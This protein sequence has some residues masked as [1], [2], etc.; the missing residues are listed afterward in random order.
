MDKYEAEVLR[1]ID[2]DTFEV[3]I[4]LGFGIV[5][6]HH[7]RLLGID[8]PEMREEQGPI[9]KKFV[10]DHLLNKRIYLTDV[11]PKTDKYGRTLAKVWLDEEHID[12]TELLL[13][14]GL[15]VPYKS[16]DWTWGGG[17]FDFAFLDF[18]RKP[19]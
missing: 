17:V 10:E 4:N 6:K 5:V 18:F 9:A 1:V 11:K 14:E 12:L 3:L 7:I 13:R 15:G 19:K 2:G 8:T 16:F